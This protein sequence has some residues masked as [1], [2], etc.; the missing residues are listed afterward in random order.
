MEVVWG[1]DSASLLVQIVDPRRNDRGSHDLC[2]RKEVVDRLLIDPSEFEKLHYIDAAVA[3][4][5]FGQEIGRTA[6]QG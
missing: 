2:P 1:E 3:A 4:L 6:H 5:A